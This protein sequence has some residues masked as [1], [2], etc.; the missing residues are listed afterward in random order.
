MKFDTLMQNYLLNFIV[1]IHL[2]D[3]TEPRTAEKLGFI[4][5]WEDHRKRAKIRY[6]QRHRSFQS[7]SGTRIRQVAYG[8]TGPEQRYAPRQ[9]Y[10]EN[11]C[12]S[13]SWCQNMPHSHLSL[14]RWSF[15]RWRSRFKLHK[16]FVQIFSTLRHQHHITSSLIIDQCTIYVG[17]TGFV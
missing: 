2:A 12:R 3:S 1:Y 7:C 8:F 13:P 11:L 15:H 4:E 17:T 6:N 10:D 9:Q 14:R 16:E 5:R